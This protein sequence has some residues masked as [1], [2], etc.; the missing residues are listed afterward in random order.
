MSKMPVQ[1]SQPLPT[2]PKPVTTGFSGNEIFCLGLKGFRPGEWVSGNSVFAME[3]F[4]SPNPKPKSGLG[5]ELKNVTALLQKGRQTACQRMQLAAR[6]YGR[7]GLAQVN[8]RVQRL[9]GYIEFVCMASSLRSKDEKEELSFSAA[10]SGQDL[11]CMLDLG[12]QPLKYVFGTSACLTSAGSGVKN[13]VRGDI[14]ALS[15]VFN[16]TRQAALDRLIKDAQSVGA[17]AVLGVETQLVDYSGVQEMVVSGTAALHPKLPSECEKNPTASNLSGA[18]LWNL[19]SMGF[20]PAGLVLAS[21]IYSPGLGNG[22]KAMLSAFD[23]AEIGHISMQIRDGR[24]QALESIT[25]Q[26]H[27]LGAETVAG[28]RTHLN[29][30]G[31]LLEIIAIGTALKRINGMAPLSPALPIQAMGTSVPTGISPLETSL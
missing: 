24:N 26:A 3:V 15:A 27:L 19:A 4:E 2:G 16:A 1:P 12:Y 7:I 14:T 5:L 23:P 6:E 13:L 8:T 31:N 18:E 11:F 21:V 10:G 9:K 22:M 30:F 17:N 28:V 29:E 25:R 20:V